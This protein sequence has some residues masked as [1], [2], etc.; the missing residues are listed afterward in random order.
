MAKQTVKKSP[1]KKT[2]PKKAPVKKAPVT[3]PDSP[4]TGSAKLAGVIKKLEF[5]QRL[6][7]RQQGVW[8]S[9]TGADA[10]REALAR[11]RVNVSDAVTEAQGLPATF[12][13]GAS[14]GAVT[15]GEGD[16]VQVTEKH[17]A[18]YADLI[19]EEGRLLVV[20]VGEQ[21]MVIAATAA[22]V[23]V[24]IRAAHLTRAASA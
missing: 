2:A 17:A 21:G 9:A 1:A 11:A 23:R 18:K 16:F 3:T 4:K 6:V 14:R 19:D 15:F 10:I 5:I 12:R 13:F 22:G 8:G 20:R 24:A 7:E